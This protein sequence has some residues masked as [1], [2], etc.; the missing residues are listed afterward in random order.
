[1][2][3]HERHRVNG[4]GIAVVAQMNLE[5]QMG[6]GRVAGGADQPDDLSYHDGLSLLDI[7][8]GEHVAV[9]GHDVAVVL[10]VDVPAAARRLR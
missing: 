3:G 1:M 9:A 8:L 2:G 5:M 6:S 10:D 7:G 4:A